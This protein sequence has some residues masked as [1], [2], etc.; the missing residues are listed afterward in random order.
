MVDIRGIKSM[1]VKGR[2][3]RCILDTKCTCYVYWLPLGNSLTIHL[4]VPLPLA[5]LLT[6]NNNTI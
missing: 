4:S 3:V 1:G 2:G 6:L 5:G